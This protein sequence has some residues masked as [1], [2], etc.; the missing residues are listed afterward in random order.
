MLG[1]RRWEDN[2]PVQDTEITG[3]VTASVIVS[4]SSQKNN[5]KTPPMSGIRIPEGLEEVIINLMETRI[6]N[7]GKERSHSKQN[8]SKTKIDKCGYS[9]LKGFCS[10]EE[11]LSRVKTTNGMGG[12]ICKPRV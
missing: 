2:D 11:T 1:L 10:A 3:W 9:K 12:N 4:V 7:R 6:F 5:P 8:A